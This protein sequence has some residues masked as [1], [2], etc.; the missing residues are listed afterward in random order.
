LMVDLRKDRARIA[1]LWSGS[2]TSRVALPV[3]AAFAFHHTRR[4]GEEVLS[5]HEYAGA[6][7]IAATAFACLVPIYRLD[8]RGEPVAVRIDLARQ[9]FRAGAAEVHCAD[10]SILAPLAIERNAVLPALVKIERAGIEYLA[11]GYARGG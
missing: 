10:G 9:R 5:P 4:G 3:A 11:P 6:L 2:L 1:E 8:G 7:D